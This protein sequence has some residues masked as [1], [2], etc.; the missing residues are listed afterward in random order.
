MSAV[1][2]LLMDRTGRRVLMMISLMGT[3]AS[4]ATLGLRVING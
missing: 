3:S 1:A 4:L 2:C